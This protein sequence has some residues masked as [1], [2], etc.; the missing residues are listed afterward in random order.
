MC[1]RFRGVSALGILDSLNVLRCLLFYALSGA[2][3][4]GVI[5][6]CTV[7]G[8]W[9]SDRLVGNHV[10][11]F[12]IGVFVGVL[13][14]VYGDIFSVIRSLGRRLRRSPLVGHEPSSSSGPDSPAA[15]DDEAFPVGTPAGKWTLEGYDT[16]AGEWYHIGGEF[17]DEQ[18]AREAARRRLE[19]LERIQP[20]SSSGGQDPGGIQDRVYIV[21]PNGTSYRCWPGD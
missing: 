6:G 18:S 1:A 15:A 13:A 14:P 2:L 7:G 20:T 21:A 11:G 8:A 3:Y 10:P 12:F 5:L 16:F 4:L 9:F 19:E 17:D